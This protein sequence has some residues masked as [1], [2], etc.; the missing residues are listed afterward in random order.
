MKKLFKMIGDAFRSIGI[1][2]RIKRA[3]QNRVQCHYYD[4]GNINPE[5]VNSMEKTMTHV[6]SQ[7]VVRYFTNYDSLE[8]LTD[9]SVVRVRRSMRRLYNRFSRISQANHV[10]VIVALGEYGAV[11]IGTY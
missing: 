8:G 2:G 1:R 10:N 5:L 7:R 3:V 9:L 11:L 6:F 4:H